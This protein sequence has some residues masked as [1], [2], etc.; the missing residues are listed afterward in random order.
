VICG[1]DLDRYMYA[2]AV[3]P[4]LVKSLKKVTH[5]HEI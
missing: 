3:R 4:K 5:A 2:L 1:F